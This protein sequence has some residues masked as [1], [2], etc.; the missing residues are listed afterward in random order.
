MKCLRRLDLIAFH[1]KTS[2]FTSLD[3]ARRID[4]ILQESCFQKTCIIKGNS[5]IK[6]FLRTHKIC[7]KNLSRIALFFN[8]FIFLCYTK[9]ILSKYC[10]ATKKG[11]K[12]TLCCRLCGHTDSEA[13][14]LA[15]HFYKGEC[16]VISPIVTQEIILELIS[17]KIVSV[18]PAR[19]NQM[20]GDIER[21]HNRFDS[22]N[23]GA[24]TSSAAQNVTSV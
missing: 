16:V 19:E 8:N 2:P 11:P 24:S 17:P 6:N 14:N 1:N 15:K 18:F 20:Y 4:T 9:S 13:Y 7:R 22:I 3:A 5:K 21:V 12:E 23:E 10:T